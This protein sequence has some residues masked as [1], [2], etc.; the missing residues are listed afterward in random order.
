MLQNQS[1][2]TEVQLFFI[3]LKPFT[4]SKGY[5]QSYKTFPQSKGSQIIVKRL[6]TSSDIMECDG[7]AD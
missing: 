7:T 1:K 3:S 4:F 2:E 6:L 5:F